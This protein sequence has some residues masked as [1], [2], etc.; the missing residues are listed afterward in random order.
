MP[1]ANQSL[2]VCTDVVDCDGVG[3]GVQRGTDCWRVRTVPFGAVGRRLLQGGP[4]M[5]SGSMATS[6][7]PGQFLPGDNFSGESKP[8][9]LRKKGLHLRTSFSA[10]LSYF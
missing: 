6:N 5:N 4:W 9:T 10:A 8:T 2:G 3:R 1:V 7:S